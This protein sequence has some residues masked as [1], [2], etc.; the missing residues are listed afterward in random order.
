[1]TTTSTL[2]HRLTSLS[3]PGCPFT[4]IKC[5]LGCADCV[6]GLQRKNYKAHI[7]DNFDKFLSHVRSVKLEN[8]QFK[9][10]MEIAKREKL[11][12]DQENTQLKVQMANNEGEKLYLEQRVV[13]LEAKVGELRK[14]NERLKSKNKGLEKEVKEVKELFSSIEGDNQ[15]LQQVVTESETKIGKLNEINR[16]LGLKNRGFENE[17]RMKQLV[18]ASNPQP[19]Q[20]SSNQHSITH[21]PGTYKPSGADFTMTDFEE[22]RRDND[23]WY[24]PPF[25]TH[26]NSYKMC[27]SV[28][29]NGIGRGKGTHLPVY[30]YLMK[31]EFDGQLEWPFKGDITI[32]LVNQEEDKDHIVATVN[33]NGNTPKEC[34]QRVITEERSDNGWGI[35]RF[36]P[37]ADLRP[38]YLKNDCIK[39]CVKKVE[40]F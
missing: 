29:P 34:C 22:Y 5:P 33:F 18:I 25:Y 31:G 39:L 26:P 2:T 7:S 32:K 21:I 40:L 19:G 1:M 14:R 36:L 12:L 4:L 30:V 16:G 9:A 20:P 28:V 35:S 37:N 38:K 17:I 6:G 3:K 13:E 11:Y 23:K 24:S 8:T 15:Y 10:Q 27:L